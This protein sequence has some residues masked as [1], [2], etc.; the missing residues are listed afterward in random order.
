MQYQWE[1][2]ETI[3]QNS[4]TFNCIVVKYCELVKQEDQAEGLL[5][6]SCKEKQQFS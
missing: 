1:S 3:I 2:L 5:T 6:R 4:D